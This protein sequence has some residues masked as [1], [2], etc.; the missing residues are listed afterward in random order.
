[1]RA[2][3]RLEKQP[4]RELSVPKDEDCIC[5]MHWLCV[6]LNSL[7][8]NRLQQ[9]AKPLVTCLYQCRGRMFQLPDCLERWRPSLNL[10]PSL[11]FP[12]PPIC[13]C[14][15]ALNDKFVWRACSS[16]MQRPRVSFAMRVSLILLFPLRVCAHRSV[17]RTLIVILARQAGLVSLERWVSWLHSLDACALLD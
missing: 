7:G 1:V 3:A 8:L 5:S 11:L 9:S 16:F 10:L 15:S 13:R 17:H 14:L 4:E 12:P 2:H 6:H